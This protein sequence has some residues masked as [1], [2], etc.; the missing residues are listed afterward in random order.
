M[1]VRLVVGALRNPEREGNLLESGG[2]RAGYPV[3]SARVPRRPVI[4][5]KAAP[6]GPERT[7]ELGRAEGETET[8]LEAV[9]EAGIEA[10]DWEK[11]TVGKSEGEGTA[12]GGGRGASEERGTER[13]ARTSIGSH[14]LRRSACAREHSSPSLARIDH[15]RPRRRGDRQPT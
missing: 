1:G 13:R 4:L 9:K 3:V 8:T 15:A 2:A 12:A 14:E 7:G 11:E 6:R 10:K 5:E